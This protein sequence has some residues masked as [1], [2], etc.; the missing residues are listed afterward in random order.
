MTESAI[1]IGVGIHKFGR[2]DGKHYSELG[3]TAVEM[4]LADAG[5]N[6]RDIQ[7]V[8]CSTVFL[9][10][11]VGVRV[12]N[13]FGR[14]G[15]P[16]VD[17]EAACAAGVSCLDMAQ[18]AIKAGK[19]DAVLALGVEKMPR[20][21]MN[22]ELIFERWQCLMG[23]SQNP[24][25]WAM[26]ARRHMHD[27][28]TTIEQIAKVAEKNH[29]NSVNNPYSMYQKEFPI[30]A[31]L[32]SPV[33]N[34]P[35]RLL[36]VCAPNEGAA[37]AIVCNERT[38]RKFS[39]KPIKIAA[40][41]HRVSQFPL[42]QVAA[43]CATPTANPT[44]H[45]LAA[46]D[47]YEEAGVGPDQID[48]AE[49]QDTDAFCEIEAYEELGFCPKGRGG[50]LIDQGITEIGGKI[51]VNASGGLISKGEPV[52]ASH[53]GQVFELVKQIRGEAGTRQINNAKVGL[54]HVYGAHGHCG[55]TILKS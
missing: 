17:V 25:Y 31:I 43:F 12:M 24:A 40:C 1:I 4:A 22:P 16:I 53:L 7:A 18:T 9:P 23:L 38:A 2:F 36:M 10:M 30:D 15:I 3:L 45:A 55:V 49:V 35:I 50:E 42:T 39:Q 52:G 44:V 19:Y 6:I 28:G 47:A 26:N 8:F 51:P 27:Y 46:K 41:V 33:I 20:G 14:T 21:F 29:R 32:K 37:A 54:A 34:D 11:S 48:F 5:M 13:H